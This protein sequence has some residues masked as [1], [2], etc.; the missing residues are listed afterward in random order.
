MRHRSCR[1]ARDEWDRLC[2][3]PVKFSLCRDA[4]RSWFAQYRELGSIERIVPWVFAAI[5]GAEIVRQLVRSY[6]E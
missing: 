6:P 2:R 3:E 5:Y 1:G 4:L